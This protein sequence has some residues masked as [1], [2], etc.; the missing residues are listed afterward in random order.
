MFV[1][2]DRSAVRDDTPTPHEID[3]W[4]PAARVFT[5]RARAVVGAL[6]FRSRFPRFRRPRA[7][8]A[9]RTE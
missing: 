1:S 6:S 3:R 2:S 8:P 5:S 7:L 4:R 9:T